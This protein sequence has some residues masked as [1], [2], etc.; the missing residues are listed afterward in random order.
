MAFLELLVFFG[1]FITIWYGAGQIVTGV[2]KFSRRLKV[3]SFAFSF[4]VLGLLTST[5]E[6][7]VGLTAISDG[8]PD[9]YIGN[10][11]GG[12]PVLFLFAIPILAILGNGLKFNKSIT[13]KNLLM[14][15][16]VM[17]LPSL[18]LIDGKITVIESVTLIVSYLVLLFFVQK[19]SGLLE[20]DKEELLERKSYSVKDF[21]RI[22][23]GAGLVMVAGHY[24]VEGT[25][26]FGSLLNL[27]TFFISLILLSLGT[28][29]PELSLAVKSVLSGKKDVAFGDYVGSGAANTLLFGIFALIGGGNVIVKDHF[30]PSFVALFAGLI[31]V[32]IL[33]KSSNILSRKEAYILVVLFVAF[34]VIQML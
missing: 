12:I 16:A 2:D 14:S 4:L 28:N 33:S 31:L 20:K 19:D 27:S 1:S 34:G 10:L 30:F 32:F 17:V 29:L 6:L 22:A 5:P 18:F 13:D 26:Y 15:F 8:K 24:I 7:G 25:I 23:Y 9:I 11:I 21:L 3:S